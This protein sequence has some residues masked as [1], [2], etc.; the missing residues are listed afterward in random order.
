[1]ADYGKIIVHVQ[2]VKDA[3]KRNMSAFLLYC[4]DTRE[5]VKGANPE[6][7]FGKL[8]KLLA[9]IWKSTDFDTKK[10]YEALAI[11]DKER[12]KKEVEVYKINKIIHEEKFSI[13]RTSTLEKV[14]GA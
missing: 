7:S 4:N 8:G 11:E 14:F 10:K 1:M 5:E 3:P 9:D 13:K 6:A 2:R 12:Y